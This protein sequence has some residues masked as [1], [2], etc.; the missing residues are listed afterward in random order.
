M[1]MGT[2]CICLQEGENEPRPVKILLYWMLSDK[3]AVFMR[4][5]GN[6]EALITE[7]DML[8]S[9]G[10]LR[11]ITLWLTKSGHLHGN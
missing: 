4:F 2:T 3:G 8:P 9:A 10:S 11:R 7:R 5:G 1:Q 6:T